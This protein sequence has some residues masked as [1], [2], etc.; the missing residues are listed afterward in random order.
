LSVNQAPE[1]IFSYRDGVVRP[2]LSDPHIE[3]SVAGLN[4]T[5]TIV[6]LGTMPR[7][8]QI[9]T[10]RDGQA[11]PVVSNTKRLFSGFGLPAIND[12]GTVAFSAGLGPVIPTGNGLYTSTG[13]EL[14]LV[15]DSKGG[16]FGNLSNPAINSRGTVAF[17]GHLADGRQGIFTGPDPVTDTVIATGDPLLGATI[18]EL[19][20]LRGLNNAG[21]VAFYFELTDRRTGIARADPMLSLRT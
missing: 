2:A 15:A 18:R 12:V 13:G 8:V 6:C 5:D 10:I 3:G 11:T 14:T 17:W 1:T 19:W 9:F 7:D 4:Q 16:V 21:Q 20:F